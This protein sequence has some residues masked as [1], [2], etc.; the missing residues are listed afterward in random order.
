MFRPFRWL[1]GAARDDGSSPNPVPAQHTASVKPLDW[2]LAEELRNS[3]C[4]FCEYHRDK[5]LDGDST[6]GERGDLDDANSTTCAPRRPFS[7]AECD[8][9]GNVSAWNECLWRLGLEL[10]EDGPVGRLSVVSLGGSTQHRCSRCG[11]LHAVA[12]ARCLRALLTDHCCIRGLYVSSALV[13]ADCEGLL[14]V[15]YGHV[16]MEELTFPDHFPDR[17][18]LC[19][20]FVRAVSSMTALRELWCSE[21]DY[22]SAKDGSTARAFGEFIERTTVLSSLTVTLL[23]TNEAKDCTLFKSENQSINL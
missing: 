10:R 9:F 14:E 8:V 17:P 16:G 1:M 2:S 21:A 7:A 13:D 18:E 22:V 11:N 5:K 23:E 3:G 4:A 12:A 15:L 20:A 19:G 6:D